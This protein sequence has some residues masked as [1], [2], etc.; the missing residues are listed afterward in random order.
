MSAERERVGAQQRAAAAGPE[1]V[2]PACSPQ[3]R[4]G[5]VRERGGGGQG[6]VQ[7]KLLIGRAVAV[8]CCL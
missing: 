2:L 1:G 5:G 7:D 8:V 4:A 3:L 6:D